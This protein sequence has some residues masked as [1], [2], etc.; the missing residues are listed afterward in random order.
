MLIGHLIQMT[1]INTRNDCLFGVNPIYWDSKKQ[2]NISRSNKEVEYRSLINNVV[3][4]MWIESLLSGLHIFFPECPVIWYDNLST[5]VL[6]TNPVC[7]SRTKHVELDLPF[8]RYRVLA[9]KLV[10]LHVPSHEQ[11]TDIFT[12]SLSISQYSF[13]RSIF[14]VI[15]MPLN[16]RED[17]DKNRRE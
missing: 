1:E 14:N 6:S 2:R 5:V 10:I 17:V 3:E 12:K 15:I 9:N 7:L 4:I 16:L 8:V 13:L 11:P